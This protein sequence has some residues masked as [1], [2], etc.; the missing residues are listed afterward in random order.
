MIGAG[1]VLLGGITIG[2]N[3]IIGANAVVIGDVPANCYAMGLPAKII[4]K[5]ETREIRSE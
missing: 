2:D 3:A 5:I 4:P 1:A